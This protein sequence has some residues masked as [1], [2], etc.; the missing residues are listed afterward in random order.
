MIDQE[1]KNI[2]ESYAK[3]V[4]KLGE[5]E[6]SSPIKKSILKKKEI[7]EKKKSKEEPIESE[8]IATKQNIPQSI[9]TRI[10]RNMSLGDVVIE[11]KLDLHGKTEQEAYDDLLFFIKKQYSNRK[12]MLLVVTG[13]SGVLKNNVPRWCVISPFDKYIMAIRSAANHHGGDGAYYILLYKY[14]G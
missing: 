7:I 13:K 5:K 1:D 14:G 2:W 10:E 11:A 3:D 9:D 12:R 6:K 8:V 4:Q